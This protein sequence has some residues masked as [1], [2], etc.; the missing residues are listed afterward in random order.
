LNRTKTIRSEQNGA[1][2]DRNARM[3]AEIGQILAAEEKLIPSS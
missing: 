2:A 3:G 1:D